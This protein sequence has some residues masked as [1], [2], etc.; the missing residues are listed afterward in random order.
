MIIGNGREAEVIGWDEKNV[1]K[2]S[3]N[4]ILKQH[5]KYEFDICDIEK[6]QN[7]SRIF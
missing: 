1:I 7:K 3:F 2:L 4:D 5:I 6:F